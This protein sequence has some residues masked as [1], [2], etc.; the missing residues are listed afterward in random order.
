MSDEPNEVTKTQEET[1]EQLDKTYLLC[2]KKVKAALQAKGATLE[3]LKGAAAM[4]ESARKRL[5]DLGMDKVVNADDDAAQL[6][7]LLKNAPDNVLD[8]P[9]LDDEPDIGQDA[10]ART[11][12]GA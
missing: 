2:V 1:S 4:L 11:A 8:M 6:K 10:H 7:E 12:A 3:D 9:A 5:H